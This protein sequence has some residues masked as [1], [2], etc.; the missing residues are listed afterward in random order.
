M[1]S[2]HKAMIEHLLYPAMELRKGNRVRA[3]TAALQ[4]S[5]SAPDLAD[6]QR[7]LLQGEVTSP[8]NPKPGCRFAARCPYASEACTKEDIP[9]KEVSPGHFV[10]CVR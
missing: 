4:A 3:K 8:V 5:A 2:L 10:A 9:L 7:E 1:P 6:K